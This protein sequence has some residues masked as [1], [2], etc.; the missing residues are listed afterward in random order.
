MK[1]IRKNVLV[2]YQKNLAHQKI[3]YIAKLR[4]LVNHAEAVNLSHEL[5][6]QQAQRRVDIYRQLIG[7]LLDDRFISRIVTCDEKW[8]YYCNPDASKQWLGPRQPG[9]LKV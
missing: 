4:Y 5:T 7:N 6:P 8:V 1:K 2:G 3:I 9:S